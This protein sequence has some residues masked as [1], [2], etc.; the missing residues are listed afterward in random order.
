MSLIKN[1]EELSTS[2]LRKDALDILEAGL[3]AINTEKILRNKIILKNGELFIDKNCYVCEHYER[4]FFVGIGK[5]AFE[6]AKVIEDILGDKLT[7]GIVLDIKSGVLNRMKSLVGTHPYPSEQNVLAAKEIKQL[8]EKATEKDLILILISGGGSS[9]LCDPFDTDCETITKITKELTKKGADIYELNIVRKHLSKI[10]GGQLAALA[11]PAQVVSLIFS[12]VIGND[13]SVIAS[14]P[15][16][17]DKTTKEDAKNVLEKY[18]IKSEVSFDVGLTETPKDSK[19]FEKVS[20]I[21]LVT[22]QDALEAMKEKAESLDYDTKIETDRLSGNAQEVGKILAKK[23]LKPKTCLLFGGETTVE[24]KGG[25]IGGR[26]QEVALSALSDLK[27][28][29]VLISA[30]SD[31]WDNLDTAGAIIDKETLEKANLISKNPEDYLSKNDSF[32]FF[33]EVGGHLSTGRTGSNVS[34]LYILI[35]ND[36][37][38]IE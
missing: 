8:V 17:I 16:V 31:G 23:E 32:N 26:N 5:C 7:E 22:N 18:E 4:I 6:G 38:K 36:P 20:N 10:Q 21:L 27:D 33:K 14:G 37:N 1:K 30:A 3:E 35:T 19:Y 24:V 29:V 25:G 12:D 9:L 34:D 11:F 13:I 28:G 15:T 2:P